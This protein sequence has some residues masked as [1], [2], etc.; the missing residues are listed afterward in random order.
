[1]SEN[2]FIRLFRL[3]RPY[4]W[5]LPLLV[6]L[7]IA[8]SLAE[9]IGIGLI[10]PLVGALMQP[11][12]SD[13]LSAIERAARQI[14]LDD[15]GDVRF[16]LV[17][18]AVFALI[19]IKTLILSVYA[20]VATSMTGRIVKDLRVSLWDR[21]VNA[22]M[23]W[24]VRSNQ[25]Q[26][27][28]TIQNQTYRA[29]E[30]LSSLTMLIVSMCTL[31]VFGTFLFLLS[32][33]MA[34]IVFAAG[35]PIFFLVR[36]ITARANRFGSELGDAYAGLSG[37]VMEL[38]SVMKT[39]RVFNQQGVETQRFA[40]A[41]DTLRASFL[42]AD[43]LSRLLPPVL[44]LVYLPI[45]FVVIG[46]ALYKGISIP[47]VLAFLLLLYRMQTPMKVL[48]GARVSLAEYSPAL[49]DV[50]LLLSTTPDER[51][52]GGGRKSRGFR[53]RIVVDELCFTYPGGGASVLRG[54]STE[55]ARGEVI[56]L[57]GPS[58]AGKSTLVNLLFGFYLPDSGR[59]LIDGE[60]LD[61]LDVYSWRE[62]IAFS[63]QDGEL[64]RGSAAYNIA[65]GVPKAEPEAIEEAARLVHAHDFLGDMPDGYES[66]VGVRG[67]LLSGGQRQRIALARALMRKPDL[68]VLDEATNAVDSATEL[69]IQSAIASLAGQATVLIIAHRTST[70]MNADR[71]LVMDEG[72]I[73]EDT[74]PS[75]MSSRAALLAGISTG[76][77][78]TVKEWD[79]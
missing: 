47:V 34:L 55:F 60:P 56:A 73:V 27:M 61:E 53:D 31:L 15:K 46:F 63:G 64:V 45:F 2:N 37:R 28:S 78:E 54:L 4:P 58:G 50:E 36:R 40:E 12:D 18:G 8:A 72:R 25:G 21:L 14:M 67:T 43:V 41:A 11:G 68:L 69:A 75:E 62:H 52:R 10:I 49:K 3:L 24:F 16:G 33:P 59:I 76:T 20:L 1:M 5:L 79:P 35:A 32:V 17:A 7:G 70:L 19:L 44:E 51:L 71:V 39:I 9:A 6:V 22:E 26:L 66:D 65:Y 74:R 42:R 13:T 77:Q 48:D 30:A 57:V 38:L 29:T 23:A